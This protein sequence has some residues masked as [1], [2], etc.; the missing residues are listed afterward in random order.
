MY[1]AR[2]R[3]YRSLGLTRIQFHPP[4]VTPLTNPAKVK[5]QGLCCCNSEDGTTAIKVES[6]AQPISLFSKMEKSS[7]VYKEE[8]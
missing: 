5:D 8:Q 7:E 4:K 2:P 6:S 3:D 1:S